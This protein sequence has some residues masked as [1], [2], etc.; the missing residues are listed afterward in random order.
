MKVHLSVFFKTKEI[1]LTKISKKI[2][3]TSFN[4]INIS[5]LSCFKSLI[6]NNKCN[7]TIIKLVL[8][9]K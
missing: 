8:L 5:F 7:L 6:I 4:L 1:L 2:A 9:N 3:K